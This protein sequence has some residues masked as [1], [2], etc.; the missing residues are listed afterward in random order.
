MRG[1]TKL[2]RLAGA[3]LFSLLMAFVLWLVGFLGGMYFWSHYGPPANDPDET[4][5]YLCGVLVGAFMAGSGGMAILWKF[6]PRPSQK[7]S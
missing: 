2:R 7:S 1:N 5:A 6:W 4:D 3:I